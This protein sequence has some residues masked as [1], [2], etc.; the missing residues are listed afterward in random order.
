MAFGLHQAAKHYYYPGWHEPGSCL[1]FIVNQKA[2]AQLP[3]DLQRIVEAVARLVNV[4]MLDEATAKNNAALNALVTEHGV[5]VSPL[6]DEVLIRLKALSE[7]VLEE[8]AA[9]DPTMAKIRD[10]FESFKSSAAQYHEI[11]EYAYY[12]ARNL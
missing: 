1:E 7:E 9:N 6:P 12:K 8:L 4:D 2:L 11:S 10:A 3:E 5:N